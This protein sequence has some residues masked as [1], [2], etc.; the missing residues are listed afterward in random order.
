[1][2]KYIDENQ[3]EN[4]I[5]AD[6]IIETGTASG[7]EYE[8]WREGKYVCRRVFTETLEHYTTVGNFYGYVSS[9]IP[10]PITFIEI[11]ILRYNAKVGNGFAIPAGDVVINKSHC[12]CYALSTAKDSQPCYFEIEVVGRWK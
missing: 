9:L 11:P 3:L 2:K 10:Y 6:Y 8:K 12:R 5:L 1:M 7:W 4:T